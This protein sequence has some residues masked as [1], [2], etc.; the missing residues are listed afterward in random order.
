MSH[1]TVI[2][3]GAV[4]LI[5]VAL[6]AWLV[7]TSVPAPVAAQPPPGQRL[8]DLAALTLQPAELE[9][10]GMPGFGLSWSWSFLSI[11]EAMAGTYA[12]SRSGVALADIPSAETVLRDAGW[13]RFHETTLSRLQPGDANLSE[14]SV[15]SSVE[16]YATAEGAAQAFAAFSDLRALNAALRGEI[17]LQSE[18]APLG[19]QSVMWAVAGIAMQ[20]GTPTTVL[21]RM[22]RI[23]SRIVSVNMVDFVDPAPID[24]AVLDRI[25]SLVI[26]RVAR[27]ATTGQ[28]C[29]PASATGVRAAITDRSGL[30]LPGLSTCV[31]RVG[32][33]ASPHYAYYTVLDGTAIPR[34]LD[35]P[36]ELM[37][38]QEDVDTLGVRDTYLMQY[39]IDRQSRTAFFYV[40]I[41]RYTDEA[42]AT[43][44][45]ASLEDQ[46][47]ADT[48]I[49]LVSFEP[50]SPLAGDASATYSWTTNS[51]GHAVTN[52]AVRIRDVVVTIRISQTEAPI[53][54]V[55]QSLLQA[56]IAC[57]QAGDCTQ[58]V[59]VPPE[60]VPAL[61]T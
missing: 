47:R 28:P 53:P 21:T 2:R 11:E 48:D 61:A 26:D 25:T 35:T 27:A 29:P 55:T 8:L 22:V 23:D 58:P 16:E 57:M 41:D 17:K 24:P 42:A 56:Q 12:E 49:T 14:F 13:Q 6:A 15:S 50:G 37:E 34:L 44:A 9:A 7:V 51:T 45:F 36:D 19:D 38:R 4:P 33:D 40:I 32:T 46:L 43:V 54:A 1:P 10:E 18:A 31:L 3:P 30:H 60:I 52:S 20:T 5:A 59:P 39:T